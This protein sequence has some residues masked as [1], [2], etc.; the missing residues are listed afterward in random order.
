VHYQPK[1]HQFDNSKSGIPNSAGLTLESR[2]V[3]FFFSLFPRTLVD[4]IAAETNKYFDVVTSGNQLSQYP[5]L[6]KWTPTDGPEIYRY[7]ATIMLM[8]QGRRLDIE[9]YWSTDIIIET[10]IFRE[11]SPF[12]ISVQLQYIRNRTQYT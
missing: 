2:E 5:E 11:V 4:L 10:P 3:D 9:D 7:L 8:T 12:P 6:K 1:S